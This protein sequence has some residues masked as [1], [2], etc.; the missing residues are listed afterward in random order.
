MIDLLTRTDP[1]HRVALVGLAQAEG[2]QSIVAETR[3]ALNDDG[4]GADIAIAVADA[5][6]QRRG[7]GTAILGMLERFA[8]AGGIV[9]LTGENSPRPTTCS[10][11]SPAAADSPYGRTAR[12]AASCA[13]RSSSMHAPAT[14]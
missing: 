13:S 6:Q 8:M 12:I 11:A 14:P 4:G 10:R 5:W 7:I 3:Y 9:R 1:P 2:R